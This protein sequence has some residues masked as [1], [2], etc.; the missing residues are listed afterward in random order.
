MA[1][2]PPA[3]APGSSPSSDRHPALL[4]TLEGL[5]ASSGDYPPN[6]SL[7]E[8]TLA[9]KHHLCLAACD[10][11]SFNCLPF[12]AA[13]ETCQ[14]LYE[15]ALFLSRMLDLAVFPQCRLFILIS[16]VCLVFQPSGLTIP[17]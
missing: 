3:S 13:F 12:Q 6:Q 17:A 16:L 11:D 7:V 2:G 9:V 4:L 15:V 10:P 8:F 1:T 5:Q 14:Y